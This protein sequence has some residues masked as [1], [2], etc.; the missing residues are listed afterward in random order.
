MP[1]AV[2]GGITISAPASDIE[3]EITELDLRSKARHYSYAR[4]KLSET[5]GKVLAKARWREPMFVKVDGTRVRRLWVPED[6]IT[7]HENLEEE[8]Y[9][10]AELI[11]PRKVLATGTF[12]KSYE[13]FT[14]RGVVE[15]ILEAKEDPE[16]VITGVEYV[17]AEDAREGGVSPLG[18]ITGATAGTTR[19]TPDG[20]ISSPR[21]FLGGLIDKAPGL[22]DYNNAITFNDMTPLG[23]MEKL[24]SVAELSWHIRQDGTLHVGPDSSYGQVIGVADGESN[25][26]VSRYSVVTSA[27]IVD[28]I[29]L[30]GPFQVGTLPGNEK[31]R[32]YLIAEATTSDF[33]G[34][35]EF[36]ETPNYAESPRELERTAVRTLQRMAM[37]DAD[38]SIEFNGMASQEKVT[39]ARTQPHDRV[40]VDSGV[41]GRCAGDVATGTFVI[42]SVQHRISATQGWEATLQVSRLPPADTITTTSVYWDAITDTRYD[43]LEAYKDAFQ[44]GDVGGPGDIRSESE[45]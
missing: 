33:D 12:D 4:A 1:C 40:V 14:I 34:S 41:G 36:V 9:A 16:G 20:L 2:P 17:N 39:L 6:G 43:T 44:S 28:T 37:Q 19:E 26:A 42:E 25:L 22:G 15:D 38:G 13:S 30:Q 3:V 35:T 11:D 8:T 29:N 24:M 31:R 27:N 7:F 10:E 21:V 23:A 18:Q 5:A 32:T 45:S